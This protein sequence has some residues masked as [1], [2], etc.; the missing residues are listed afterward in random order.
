VYVLTLI[1]LCRI[2]PAKSQLTAYHAT[3][4]FLIPSLTNTKIYSAII[5][6]Y[7][8]QPYDYIEKSEL[9]LSG[10]E[11]MLLSKRIGQHAG[12]PVSIWS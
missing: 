9:G 8:S 11:D 3:S 2:V 7:I 10:W 12:I 1:N 6:Q 5:I 4:Y